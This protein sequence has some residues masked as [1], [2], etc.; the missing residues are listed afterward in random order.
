[1]SARRISQTVL[2]II[3]D[4]DVK[5]EEEWYQLR[6]LLTVDPNQDLG[7]CDD[8][9]ILHQFGIACKHYLHR[10]YLSVAIR[11]VNRQGYPRK[12]SLRLLEPR[13]PRANIRL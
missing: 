8:C 7:N 3:A 11:P 9:A 12:M 1:M 10:I 4:I 6:Q 13:R 2:G 5:L